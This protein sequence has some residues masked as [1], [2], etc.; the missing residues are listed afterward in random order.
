[1]EKWSGGGRGGGFCG[2]STVDFVGAFFGVNVELG[3]VVEGL[4]IVCEFGEALLRLLT[5]SSWRELMGVVIS[6]NNWIQ[7][8]NKSQEKQKERERERKKE[9][10]ERNELWRSTVRISCGT[11][12]RKR[13]RFSFGR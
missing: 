8:K 4:P 7:E 5:L 2:K 10:N 13:R 12:C 6:T 9:R 11:G 1:L 3:G